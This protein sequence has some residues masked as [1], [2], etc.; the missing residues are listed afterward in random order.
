MGPRSSLGGVGSTMH[1]GVDVGIP[2][3][4]QLHAIN[5]GP[6]PLAP[7]LR[8]T[9]PVGQLA[10]LTLA[11]VAGALQPALSEVDITGTLV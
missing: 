11:K 7:P 10:L 9:G 4:S 1:Q 8:R 6:P 2:I 5:H 3:G